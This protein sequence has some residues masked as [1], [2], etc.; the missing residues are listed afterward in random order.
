MGAVKELWLR[1]EKGERVRIATRLPGKLPRNTKWQRESDGWTLARKSPEEIQALQA[2]TAAK[3][4]GTTPRDD[5]KRLYLIKANYALLDVDELLHVQ[6]WIGEL[7]T[8]KKEEKRKAL[9][10]QIKQMQNQ[11]HNLK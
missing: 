10:D 11:L 9:E 8:E 3:S 5:L 7:L 4:P 2:G 6:R 1:I